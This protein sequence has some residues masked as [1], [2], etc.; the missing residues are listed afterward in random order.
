MAF[1]ADKRYKATAHAFQTLN[2]V[3]SAPTPLW[4]NSLKMTTAPK[5]KADKVGVQF[6]P[7]LAASSTLL[8][9]SSYLVFIFAYYY[10]CNSY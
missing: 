4:R 5:M 3:L 9:E 1:T 10:N 2:E 8:R 7:E 6:E